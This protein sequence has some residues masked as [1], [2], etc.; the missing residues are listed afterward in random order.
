MYYASD[1]GDNGR[2]VSEIVD[3]DTMR[4]PIMEQNI[5]VISSGIPTLR[6]SSDENL[7][8]WD[9]TK[10]RIAQSVRRRPMVQEDFK[11][12]EGR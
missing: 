10:I 11:L 8:P 2:A 1:S 12:S 6:L 4:I 7:R 9:L 5:C 3:H